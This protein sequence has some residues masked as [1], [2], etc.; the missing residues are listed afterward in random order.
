GSLFASALLLPFFTVV[1]REIREIE[2]RGPLLAPIQFGGAVVL[3]TF[4]QIIGL[5]WL[6]AS[7]RPAIDPEIIRAA[8]DYGWLVWTILIPTYMM[9]FICMAIA[10]FIDYRRRPLWPRWAGYANLWVATLGAGGI[11]AVFFK[12]GP[13]SWNGIV[14]WWMPTVV[15]AIG[16]TMNMWLMHRHA[17]REAEGHDLQDRADSRT[18]ARPVGVAMR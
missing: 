4:F 11:C 16:M 2:G 5:L 13:F 3:V 8:T 9:Q 15:F 1:S 14:G 12:T 18:I 10:A 17:R 6:L 7:F